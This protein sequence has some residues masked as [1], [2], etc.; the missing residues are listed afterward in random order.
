MSISSVSFC[1]REWVEQWGGVGNF[2]GDNTSGLVPKTCRFA[3]PDG[4]VDFAPPP[5]MTKDPEETED[6]AEEPWPSRASRC[7]SDC[8]LSTAAM[9][10]GKWNEAVD[11][12]PE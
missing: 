11:L 5:I 3:L 4:T 2:A 1:S 10:S 7:A 6:L 12:G 9:V 8:G